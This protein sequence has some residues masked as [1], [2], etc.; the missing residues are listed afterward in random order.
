MMI[1][2]MYLKD[3]VGMLLCKVLVSSTCPVGF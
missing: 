2:I 3:I 1:A